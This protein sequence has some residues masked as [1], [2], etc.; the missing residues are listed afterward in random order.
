MLLLLAAFVAEVAP[1]EGGFAAGPVVEE[2]GGG[3][4]GFIGD[5]EVEVHLVVVGGVSEEPVGFFELV[6]DG[7]LKGV[8]SDD[9]EGLVTGPGGDVCTVEGAGGSTGV[10]T[11]QAA[12]AELDA[13]KVADDTDD[14]VG[15]V[16]FFEYLQNWHTSGARGFAIVGDAHGEAA[17]ANNPSGADVGGLGVHVFDFCDECA[18]VFLAVNGHGIADEARFFDD[19]FIF[20]IASDAAVFIG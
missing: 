7:A 10:G 11:Y 1:A 17:V 12:S 15:E 4:G 14:D 9:F 16:F 5:E 6:A 20:T 19:K 18:G 3:V 8:V 13:A 2:V